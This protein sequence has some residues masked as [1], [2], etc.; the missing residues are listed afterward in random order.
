MYLI[1]IAKTYYGISLKKEYN[2]TPNSSKRKIL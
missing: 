1:V 2:A